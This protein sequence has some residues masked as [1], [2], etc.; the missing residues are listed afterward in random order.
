KTRLAL[1]P[2]VN[3][4]WSSSLQGTPW[5]LTPRTVPSGVGAFQIEL[6]FVGHELTIATQ[7]GAREAMPLRAM[8]VAQFYRDLLHAMGDLGI[9]APQI[10]PVPVEV[11]VAVPFLEDVQ[12]RPYD[13]ADARSFA[14]ALLKTHLVF[15]RF[16]TA[17]VGNG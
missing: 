10:V 8:S 4:W 13:R 6:H 15:E 3:Q 9:T 11:A 16:R 2:L 14:H 1:T 5:G 12:V 17:D 7:D